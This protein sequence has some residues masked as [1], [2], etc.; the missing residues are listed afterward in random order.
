MI[1]EKRGG[2][3]PDLF[4]LAREVPDPPAH[5]LEPGAAL[6]GVA[7]GYDLDPRPVEVAFVDALDHLLDEVVR[8]VE[9][10]VRAAGAR[11]LRRRRPRHRRPGVPAAAAAAAAAAASASPRRGAAVE[12][13]L[14]VPIDPLVPRHRRIPRPLL[15]RGSGR[16]LPLSDHSLRER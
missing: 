1:A 9:V 12:D 14:Q 11:R 7:R 2:R 8:G 13:R 5:V 10:H 15:F 3:N 6:P 4:L 16:P